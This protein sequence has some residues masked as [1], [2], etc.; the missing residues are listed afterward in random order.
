M[1]IYPFWVADGAAVEIQQVQIH[2][3]QASMCLQGI[4]IITVKSV[5]HFAAL[6]VCIFHSVL[7]P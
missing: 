5:G 6:Y 2:I 4:S 3:K 1:L 7:H